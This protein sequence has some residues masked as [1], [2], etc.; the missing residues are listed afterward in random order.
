[1]RA[2]Y[3]AVLLSAA[4]VFSLPSWSHAQASTWSL[5]GA[6]VQYYDSSSSSWVSYPSITPTVTSSPLTDGIKIT[7]AGV[8]GAV[9][10]M[11][12]TQITGSPNPV[13]QATNRVF[14]SGT[15]SLGFS[16]WDSA[17]LAIPTT[18]GFGFSIS[19]GQLSISNAGTE[20]TLLDGSSNPLAGVGSGFGPPFP[21]F[22]PYGPGGYGVGFQFVDGF[23]GNPSAGASINWGVSIYFVWTPA[24]NGDVLTFTIPSDSIDIQ[25]VTVP[26]PAIS[27]LLGLAGMWLL[28]RRRQ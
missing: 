15:A 13:D 16:Q 10:S 18:F 8:D 12:G 22:G 28:G 26:E 24:A 9:F 5:S 14:L 27:G 1:M 17:S 19:D 7:G 25:I 4:L 21:V 6:Q 3:A 11:D 2:F 20:F 23:G